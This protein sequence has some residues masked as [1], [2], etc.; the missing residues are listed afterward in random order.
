MP[1]GKYQRIPNLLRPINKARVKKGRCERF[2]LTAW[3]T[4]EIQPGLYK[5]TIQVELDSFTKRKVFGPIV[6]T[7]NGVTPIGCKWVFVRKRNEKNEILRY[8]ARLVA[9]D[10]S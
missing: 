1:E 7:P 3:V 10:F 4:S 6:H 8:K 2:W 9:Q 5:G